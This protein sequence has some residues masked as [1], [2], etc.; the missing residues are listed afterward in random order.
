MEL[1]DLSRRSDVIEYLRLL[2][3]VLEQEY[4]NIT[5]FGL[6]P[7]TEEYAKNIRRVAVYAMIANY[8]YY[9]LCLHDLFGIKNDFDFY[10]KDLMDGLTLLDLD[11]R[12]RI[13]E[14]NQ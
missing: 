8:P 7:D 9:A 13:R 1:N 11:I 4:Q 12:R 5:T 14:L 10:G 6:T 2:C 3:D